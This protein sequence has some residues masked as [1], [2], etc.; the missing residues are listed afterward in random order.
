MKRRLAAMGLLV[1][2][3][4]C[5]ACSAK[6]EEVKEANVADIVKDVEAAYGEDFVANNVL[7]NEMI[8]ELIGIDAEWCEQLYA[9]NSMISVHP[10]MFI[11]AE[12]K[13]G[14]LDKVKDAVESYRESIVS[15]TMQ[16]PMNIQKTQASR[17]DVYGNYVFFT[18]LGFIPMELEDQG[19]DA[20]L[21]A[22]QELNQ[23]AVDVI[24]SYL[25]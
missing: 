8:K 19:D 11:A 4:L 21:A 7:D 20:M 2:T 10:D 6:K 12:A 3:M 23:K 15:D 1:V 22:Y 9:A 24:E 17:V 5:S 14:D 13:E 25:K 18:L 16:Y